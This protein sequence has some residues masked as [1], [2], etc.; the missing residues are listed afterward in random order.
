MEIF[1]DIDSESSNH[2]AGEVFVDLRYIPMYVAGKPIT[3]KRD[4]KGLPLGVDLAGKEIFAEVFCPHEVSKDKSAPN[5]LQLFAKS[6]KIVDDKEVWGSY[7]GNWCN[8]WGAS[9]WREDPALGNVGCDTWEK[10]S[11]RLPERMVMKDGKVQNSPRCGFVDKNFDPTNIALIGLKFGLNDKTKDRIRQTM[12]LDNL[13]WGE[14]ANRVEFNFDIIKNPI[15]T[16][17]DNEYNAVAIV[18]TEYMKNKY[19]NTI[20]PIVGKSHTDKEVKKL[21]K[22]IRGHG[23]RLVFKPHVDVVS[24]DWRGDIDPENKA[25]WFKSYAKFIVHYAKMA[26]DCNADMLVFATELKSMVGKN[27]EENWKKIINKVRSVYSGKLTYAANWDNYK[28]VCFW[29]SLDLIGID[30]Y[31]PLSEKKDPSMSDL[32]KGWAKWVGEVSRFQKKMNKDITFTEIGYRST[33]FAAKAPSEFMKDRAVNQKLQ[34]LCYK[35]VL[36]AFKK[37]SWFKGMFFWRWSPKMDEG[38]ANNTGFT[39]QHKMAEKVFKNTRK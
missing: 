28:E 27:K 12:W 1:L 37:K 2:K 25:E 36:L 39:P 14:I 18:Q 35:S 10:I 11:M 21:A 16:L 32:M 23:M 7:Y 33:D 8:I 6:V 24:G 13:G 38:G 22:Y 3:I 15:K 4:Q 34:M 26:E 29:N 19:S 5:G 20:N 31:F 17:K 9:A 30:A